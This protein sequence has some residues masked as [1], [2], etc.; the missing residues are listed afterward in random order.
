MFNQGLRFISD[1]C[2]KVYCSWLFVAPD[3]ARTSLSVASDCITLHHIDLFPFRK[4]L[5]NN[6]EN[7]MV[8]Y[9]LL[10][11]SPSCLRT[12][13]P[14][15]LKQASK[16]VKEVLYVDIYQ[17]D[18][19]CLHLRNLYD[20]LVDVYSKNSSR[21]GHL[22]VRFLLPSALAKTDGNLDEVRYLGKRPEVALVRD[23][24]CKTGQSSS[25]VGLLEFKKWLTR[26][27]QLSDLEKKVK[28]LKVEDEATDSN[29]INKT[30]GPENPQN[31]SLQTYNEV[32]LGGTFDHIHSGHRL[33]L[34]VASL[35]C[36][37]RITIGLSDGPLLQRKF[38]KELIEPFQERRK[39]LQDFLNDVKPGMSFISF[40]IFEITS[41]NQHSDWLS[42]VL[43]ASYFLE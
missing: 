22:D 28:Y 30:C 36:E 9:G 33:L 10:V 6:R 38:L 26:R 35:L 43:L 7:N 29:L 21:I 12:K 16:E 18:Y 11:L 37:E 4:E 41:L 39:K 20:L 5:R 8:R 1:D 42:N 34:A 24:F 31:D 13:I 2:R 40:I 14:A 17:P 15:L 25:Q 27:F 23:I 3:R 19:V 32:V